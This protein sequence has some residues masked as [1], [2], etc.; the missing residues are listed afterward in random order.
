MLNYLTINTT[1]EIICFF[2]ALFCLKQ[3]KKLVWFSMVLFVLITCVAE[4]TG[5]YVKRLNLTDKVHIHP[6]AWVYNILIFFQIGFISW[7]FKDI[8]SKYLKTTYI[9]ILGLLFVI[10]HIYNITFRSFLVYDE[11]TKT[12]M[13]ILFVLN[14]LTFYYLLLKDDFHIKLN[15]FSAFWWVSGILFFYFG[16]TIYNVFYDKLASLTLDKKENLLYLKYLNNA[17]NVILYSCWAYSFI[18]RKWE[19]KRS[20][21]LL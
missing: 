17:L 3:E 16:T 7:M 14:S 21:S 10:L 11:T 8:L 2:V 1:V 4:I 6:N 13:S 15:S 12:A 19:M 9:V 18:C 20:E 5:I